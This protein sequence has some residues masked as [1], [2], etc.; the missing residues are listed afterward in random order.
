[1]F[2]RVV[3]GDG[4]APTMCGCAAPGLSA[5][6]QRLC[7]WKA[8]GCAGPAVGC[9]SQVTG[10]RAADIE[11]LSLIDREIGPRYAKRRQRVRGRSLRQ[12]FLASFRAFGRS[13]L[14]GNG[15]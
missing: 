9:G 10:A 15:C 6:G 2:T 8:I 14:S 12:D 5:Q 11:T 7:G 13:S 1:M 4:P 3:T